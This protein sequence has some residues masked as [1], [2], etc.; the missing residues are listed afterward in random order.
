M[1]IELQRDLTDL[2]WRFL[3]ALDQQLGPDGDHDVTAHHVGD[4]ADLDPRD[5][6]EAVAGLIGLR[7]IREANADDRTIASPYTG[8]ALDITWRGYTLLGRLDG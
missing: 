5:Q 1:T 6:V 2:E 3:L 4:A 7:L 8:A